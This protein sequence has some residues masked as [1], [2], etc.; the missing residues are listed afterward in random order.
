MLGDCDRKKLYTE[1]FHS[2]PIKRFMYRSDMVELVS[3]SDR[4]SS[5]IK[6]IQVGD[7]LFEWKGVAVV[8]LRTNERGGYTLWY[9]RRYYGYV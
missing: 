8:K 3:F 6:N 5:Q 1:F 4:S 9:N 7:D 2:K